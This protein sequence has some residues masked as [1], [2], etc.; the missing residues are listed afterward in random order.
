MEFT[1]E[2]CLKKAAWEQPKLSVLKASC[3]QALGTSLTIDW[4]C[5]TS[6]RGPEK[7]AG[8]ELQAVVLCSF[9]S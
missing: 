1:E 5:S 2:P 3:R 7:A 6:R 4:Q 9:V 8:E